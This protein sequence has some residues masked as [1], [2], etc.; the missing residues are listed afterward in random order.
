MKQL[1]IAYQLYFDDND[2]YFPLDEANLGWDD[3]LNGYDGRNVAYN[4]LKTNTQIRKSQYNAGIY[5]CPSDDIPRLYGPD[6]DALTFSYSLTSF[7]YH[8]GAVTINGSERGVTGFNW[9]GGF[10]GYTSTK[11]TNINKSSSTLSTFEY[12]SEGKCLGRDWLSTVNP[13]TFFTSTANVPHDG[14]DKSNYLF[15][16]GHVESL[17]AY[18]T[19]T[20]EGGGMGTASATTGTMWDAHK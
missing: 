5:A 14:F 6:P 10:A 8:I 13:V 4:H 18:A 2:N 3:K 15:V 16:D 19:L 17:N 12:M 20:I 9:N 1:S 7:I 11:I